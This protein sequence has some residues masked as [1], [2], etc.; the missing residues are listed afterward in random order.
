MK[1][2]RLFFTE[3]NIITQTEAWTYKINQSPLILQRNEVLTDYVIPCQRKNIN[4]QE[5]EKYNYMCTYWK[6]LQRASLVKQDVA[7]RTVVRELVTSDGK[8]QR[9]RV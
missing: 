6:T 4:K 1:A 9:S 8:L 2:K 5:L 7:L 3:G